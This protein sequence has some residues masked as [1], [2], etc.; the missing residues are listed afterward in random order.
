[1]TEEMKLFLSS[2]GVSSASIKSKTAQ[3]II[4]ALIPDDSKELIK[5]GYRQLQEIKAKNDE[6]FVKLDRT[7]AIIECAN[8]QEMSDIR[9]RDIIAMYS[10]LLKISVEMSTRVDDKYGF[11]SKVP[12][13]I[14]KAI[15]EISYIVYAYAANGYRED[16]EN[17]QE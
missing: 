3:E 17:E 7:A 4:N 15:R 10:S 1:M 5:E 8:E 12:F 14:N 13:D 6:L 11:N 9:A 16:R 2:Q